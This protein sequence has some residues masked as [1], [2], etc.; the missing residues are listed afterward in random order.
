M[1]FKPLT[2]DTLTPRQHEIL[3]DINDG[4]RGANNPDRPAAPSGLFNIMLRAP[5][6]ANH[7]QKVG[8]YLRYGSSLE[9]RISEFGIIITA[10]FWNSQRV[11]HAHCK[12]ALKAG[13][14]P[15]T[16]DDL[17]HGRTPPAA[18]KQDEAVAWRYCSELLQTREV[19][20]ATFEATRA[21][22]GEQGVVDLTGVCGYYSLASMMQNISKEPLPAGVPLPLPVL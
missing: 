16:A 11:W 13:L 6:L 19:S 4:P 20:D 21:Q 3:R 7:A 1:R 17:A 14:D 2:L 8:A 5:E 18:M 9:E 22:F 10:R 15:R 12:I